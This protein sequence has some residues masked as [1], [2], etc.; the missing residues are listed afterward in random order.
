M[1]G[2]RPFAVF[3][4]NIGRGRI[5]V[6]AF[7]D[8]TDRPD[9]EGSVFTVDRDLAIIKEYA[10]DAD[11]RIAFV[12]LGSMSVYPSPHERKQVK[13][14]IES[15]AD[16][17]ICTGSHFIK[18]FVF[19]DGKPVFYGLGNHLFPLSSDSEPV[20]MHA[21][22]GFRDGKLAQVFVVPFL[23]TILDGRSGPLDETA[24]AAFRSMLLDRSTADPK[25]YFSDPG[26]LEKL[27]RRLERLRLSELLD[28]RRRHVAYTINILYHHY[29]LIMVGSIVTS[30]VLA[31]LVMRW[32]ILAIRLRRAKSA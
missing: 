12:H 2:I 14:V 9:P 22:L 20:G 6:V 27:R 18:G 29:P 23:N 11:F 28:L 5:A 17:V 3:H 25:R 8:Y 10:S 1:I 32:T 7:T 4:E 16:M 31:V 26:S 24:F 13:R 21:V 30:M 15:G 19:E